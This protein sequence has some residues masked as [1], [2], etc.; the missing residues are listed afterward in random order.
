M[1]LRPSVHGNAC[2]A[3]KSETSGKTQ[4]HS[5]G[6]APSPLRPSLPKIA[7]VCAHL[8][9]LSS[10]SHQDHWLFTSYYTLR[11]QGKLR[12]RVIWCYAKVPQQQSGAHVPATELCLVQSCLPGVGR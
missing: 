8:S 11:T 7:M 6:P 9:F 5:P 10:Q 1:P 4:G 2:G 12:P 3:V